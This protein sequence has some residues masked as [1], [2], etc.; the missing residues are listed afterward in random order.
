MSD[1]FRVKDTLSHWLKN[2]WKI[3]LFVAVF[4][5]LGLGASFILEPKY[6]AEV[7][8]DTAIDQDQL[9]FTGMIDQFNDPLTLSQYD[10]DLILDSVYRSLLQ[11]KQSAFDYTKS[12][13]PDLDR[14]DF[15]ENVLIERHHYNWFL[16]FRHPNPEIAQSVVNYW[17][18]ANIAQFTELQASGRIAPYLS[19]EI[20]SLAELPTKPIYQNRLN[21]TVAGAVIGLALGFLVIDITGRYLH[22]KSKETV[23]AC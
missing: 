18:K 17:A 23:S 1:T 8:F 9:D 15:E 10:V 6:E 7:I 19:V 4:G 11:V 21:L 22:M 12:L 13:D 16:R 2:W 20:K 3:T 5:A 14:V